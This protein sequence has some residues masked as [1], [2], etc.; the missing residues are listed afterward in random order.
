M[1]KERAAA[2]IGR[3][4]PA[5]DTAR[6]MGCSPGYI[7]QLLKEDDFKL[8]VSKYMNEMDGSEKAEEESIHA[9]YVAAE[10]KILGSILSN[11]ENAEFR[12]QVKALQVIADRQEKVLTRKNPHAAVQPG[13]NLSVT[14]SLTLP[15]HAIPM[16]PVIE[17]NE[18]SEVVA[19][20]NKPMAPMSST[21][22]ASLFKRKKEEAATLTLD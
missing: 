6:I 7:S 15:Q 14:V 19:I 21:A 11:V 1:N 16:K 8:M 13:Q 22:V 4:V 20:D 17:L 12:D 18:R 9:K 10:H 2:Y 3:G 5:A